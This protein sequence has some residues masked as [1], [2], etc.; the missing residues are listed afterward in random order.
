MCSQVKEVQG[1]I[2][3]RT[4]VRRTKITRRKVEKIPKMRFQV[5]RNQKERM[6]R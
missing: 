6:R 3:R 1:R 2:S 5:P 4:R